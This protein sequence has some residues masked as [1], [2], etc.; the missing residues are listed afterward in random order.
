VLTTGKVRSP[1]G[2]QGNFK[3]VYWRP[4]ES[5]SDTMLNILWRAEEN[6]ELDNMNAETSIYREAMIYRQIT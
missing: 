5:G 3:E 6:N 2:M 4:Q 1:E